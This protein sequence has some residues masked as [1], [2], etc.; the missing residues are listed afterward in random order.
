MAAH[1]RAARKKGRGRLTRFCHRLRKQARAF[2]AAFC[3]TA[4]AFA[5]SPVMADY[6]AENG[7]AAFYSGRRMTMV[8][9]YTP[10]GGD[11]Q[12]ERAFAGM[13]I[14]SGLKP[15]GDEDLHGR[16]LARH[17]GRHIPG[18]PTFI[19]QTMP[20]A[21]GR[22]A[23]DY[24]Y[25]R[26]PRDGSVIGNLER[27]LATEPLL[28]GGDRA[29]AAGADIAP[30]FAWIGSLR[31]ETGFVI[32]WGAA[33]DRDTQTLFEREMIVGGITPDD[34]SVRLARALNALLGTRFKIIGGYTGT[35]ELQIAMERG[36]IAGFL[37]GSSDIK[38][39]LIPW[40][41]SGQARALLQLGLEQDP[42]LPDVPLALEFARNADDRGALAF[43][44]ARQALGSPYAAPPGTPAEKVATLRRAFDATMRDGDFLA[45]AARLELGIQP[46]S[47]ETLAALLDRLASTPVRIRTRAVD[48][49]K[50]KPG[51]N[52]Q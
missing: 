19:V 38:T 12:Q 49:I 3:A 23:A 7:I 13:T 45:D 35:V 10:E 8:S 44:F 42:A 50:Q 25:N 29:N 46:L 48:A 47:G 26:A 2:A 18:R 51:N 39:R 37:A 5:E 32:A 31:G 4:P 33:R 11:R 52:A 16:L 21:G 17:I 22:R 43:I 27:G 34:D 41:Q 15:R 9:G 28:L 20:G 6:A 24:L 36:E 14:T 40:A 1:A 30:A